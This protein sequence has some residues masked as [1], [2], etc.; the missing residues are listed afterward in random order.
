MILFLSS[1]NR[2]N[3]SMEFEV[4]TVVTLQEFSDWKEAG[5]ELVG[6]VSGLFFSP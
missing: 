6:S 5:R 3:S 2:Q 1:Q 4:G